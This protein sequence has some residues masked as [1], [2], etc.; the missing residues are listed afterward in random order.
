MSTDT[1]DSTS[2]YSFPLASDWINSV[3]NLNHGSYSRLPVAQQAHKYPL[4]SLSP[5]T[6]QGKQCDSCILLNG[7]I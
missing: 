6:E 5:L 2:D 1:T 4:C 7:L 3:T